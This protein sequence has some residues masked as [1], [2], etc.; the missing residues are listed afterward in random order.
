MTFVKVCAAADVAKG[1]VIAAKIDDAEIAV[2]HAGDDAFYAVQD[3]CSHASIALSEERQK[4]NSVF[5]RS[6]LWKRRVCRSS[7]S[8]T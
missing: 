8:R 5:S 7:A 3:E 1:E 4:L 2:V 6:I